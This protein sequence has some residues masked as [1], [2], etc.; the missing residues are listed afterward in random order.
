[1]HPVTRIVRGTIVLFPLLFL[2]IFFVYPLAAILRLSLAP[3][4][5]PALQPVWEAARSGAVWR[6]LWFTTWQALAS[7]AL[8]MALGLPLA[9][10][11]ARYT[12]PGKS[13]LRALT[14]IPFVMPTVVVGAA[15]TTL[16]GPT[17]IINNWLRGGLGLAEPPIQLM[18]TIYIKYGISFRN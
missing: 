2:A 17:G 3:E 1:M 4:G 18:N 8:T 7:T 5:V 14:T 16:I 12:F 13:A 6:I 10:I 15:F 11:F 9:A